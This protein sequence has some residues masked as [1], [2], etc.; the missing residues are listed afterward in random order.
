MQ[1][2]ENGVSSRINL[3]LSPTDILWIKKAYPA[4]KKRTILDSTSLAV[5]PGKV[6]DESRMSDQDKNFV[7]SAY[8][9][10]YYIYIVIAVLFIVFVFACVLINRRRRRHRH[11]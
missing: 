9:N 5:F 8:F 1:L 11:P 10:E 3:R 7:I 4:D 2:T 6:F